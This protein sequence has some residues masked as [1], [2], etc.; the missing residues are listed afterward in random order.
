VLRRVLSIRQLSSAAPRRCRSIGEVFG[1]QSADGQRGLREHL[2]WSSTVK[3]D[4]QDAKTDH[5]VCT[6]L[7]AD[8]L[9]SAADHLGA[10]GLSCRERSVRVATR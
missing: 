3:Q 8:S 1:A 2:R 10:E 9:R 5:L 7:P 4:D 6:A